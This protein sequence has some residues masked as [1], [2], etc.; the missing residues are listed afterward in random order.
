M[1]YT[2]SYNSFRLMFLGVAKPTISK[3]KLLFLLIV[4]LIY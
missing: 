1:S 2:Y 3:Y 4:P